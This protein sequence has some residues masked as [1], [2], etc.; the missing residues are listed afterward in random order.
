[1]RSLMNPRFV[2]LLLTAAL[3]WVAPASARDHGHDH[4]DDGRPLTAGKAFHKGVVAVANPYGAEAGAKI[5]EAGGNAIDAAVAIAYALNVVEPQSAGIGGG[6]FMMIHLAPRAARPSPSI[7]ASARR[8]APRR[9][10]S[11]A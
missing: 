10:C 11:S 6:G 7:R 1:M 2:T 3:A 8:R 9:T 4:D 5:L